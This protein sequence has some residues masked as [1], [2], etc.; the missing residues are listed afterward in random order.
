MATIAERMRQAMNR[1]GVA[2][3]ELV[4]RT[5]IGKSSISTY[6]KGSY[7]PKQKNIYKIAKAL[8]VNE[9]WLM[10]EDVPMARTELP[11]GAETV[12]MKHLRRIPIL[13]RIA[14]GSPIYAEENIEGYTYTDL[15]GGS[16]YFALRVRGDSMN[17][18]RINDGDLVIIRQQETVENGQI[19][20][21]MVGDDEAT[22]KRFRQDGDMITLMPQSMNPAHQPMVF[23][24]KKTAVHVLGLVVKVEFAPV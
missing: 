22:L 5:G 18:A 19:A 12:D 11:P 8:N 13:W 14:C 24:A 2:Q 17:A 7:E 15:N 1:S 20:A 23:D 9:A 4:A 10:G 6:L 21:V 16:D 3:A